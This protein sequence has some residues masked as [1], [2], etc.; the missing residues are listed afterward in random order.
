MSPENQP[1]PSGEEDEKRYNE[2]A[3]VPLSEDGLKDLEAFYKIGGVV[4]H[5]ELKEAPVRI[6]L[7]ENGKYMYDGGDLLLN[8]SDEYAEQ[9][10]GETREMLDDINEVAPEAIKALNDE[11]RAA[12]IARASI[13]R[14]KKSSE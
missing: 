4:P 12:E 2:I 5:E 9:I 14:I 11:G 8:I 10:V 13:A 7:D 3:D 1:T 6:Q